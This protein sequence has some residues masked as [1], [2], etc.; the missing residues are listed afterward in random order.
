MKKLLLITTI[1]FTAFF[2][3]SQ[4]D[5]L[6]TLK[7]KEIIV[8]ELM[9]YI[10]YKILESEVIEER[11]DSNLDLI[12][13]PLEDLEM[14]HELAIAG[15]LSNIKK[16]ATELLENDS[17]YALFSKNLIEL[18]TNFEDEEIIELLESYL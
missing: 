16:S 10:P 4:S 3:H 9:K 14:L 7:L 17:K 5:S 8:E 15:D 18:A 1:V 11:V 13:P 2:S 6:W 12:T